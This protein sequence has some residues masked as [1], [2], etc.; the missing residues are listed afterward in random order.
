MMQY[1]NEVKKLREDRKILKTETRRALAET[2]E[3]GQHLELLRGLLH[4]SPAA[5]AASKAVAGADGAGEASAN[6]DGSG[7]TGTAGDILAVEALVEAEKE[8]DQLLKETDHLREREAELEELQR[9][10]KRVAEATTRE[11]EEQQET[12]R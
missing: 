9:E 1:D 6:G 3:K 8:R 5:A 4:A 7:A 12:L 10:A 2:K 11:H